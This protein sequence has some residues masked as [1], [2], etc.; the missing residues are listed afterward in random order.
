MPEE[1]AFFL[2]CAIVEDILPEYYSKSM[3]G[4][5]VDLQVF[6]ELV[7][8]HLPLIHD[9]LQMAVGGVVLVTVPWFMCLFIHCLPWKS[10]F[11]ALDLIFSEG[12]RALF[13][14]GLAVLKTCERQILELE[15]DALLA[16]L[17]E[18]L[19]HSLPT[20]ELQKNIKMYDPI[21]TVDLIMELREI[22]RP[23]L[24]GDMEEEIHATAE[25]T[26][27]EE[28]GEDERSSLPST[29]PAPSLHQATVDL[30]PTPCL[31]L[32]E[33]RPV[34]PPGYAPAEV[35]LREETPGL[36][37]AKRR[38][39]ARSRASL[40]RVPP[41]PMTPDQE[42]I[43]RFEQMVEENSQEY[44]N[45]QQL[46]RQKRTATVRGFTQ[47]DGP[48]LTPRGKVRHNNSVERV[49]APAFRQS[50]TNLNLFDPM[51]PSPLSST[52]SSLLPSSSS[53]S[54]REE[55]ALSASQP[56]FVPR[57]SPRE[58]SP[59][60]ASSGGPGDQEE[61]EGNVF[62]PRPIPRRL[63]GKRKSNSILG[64]KQFMSPVR[65][66][67][68]RIR[69]KPTAMEVLSRAPD[70]PQAA[71]ASIDLHMLERSLDQAKPPPNSPLPTPSPH[72]RRRESSL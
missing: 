24:I 20:G 34:S 43:N 49:R 51:S 17:K 52:V 12:S 65:V 60:A 31:P 29:T 5:L 23:L 8:D 41:P 55:D 46:F 50:I 45:L 16:L 58:K 56:G 40:T 2:L 36:R 72:A 7:R 48:L 47:M 1:D 44:A 54:L 33:E 11:R 15:G 30:L 70:S 4:S 66:S 53:S 26:K 10:T 35:R 63:T 19:V 71:R 25:P 32:P 3:I 37:L 39:L 21:V 67:S 27:E 42:N 57:T 64:M 22:H 18:N 6:D 68:V 69:E 9:H 28:E 62:R 61:E 38:S 13:V 59:L 14:I